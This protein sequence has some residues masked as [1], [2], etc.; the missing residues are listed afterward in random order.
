MSVCPTIAILFG[1]FLIDYAIL[2]MISLV[3]SSI[4][5]LLLARGGPLIV[6]PFGIAGMGIARI[7]ANCARR[8]QIPVVYA[9]C[10]SLSL[11]VLVACAFLVAVE[12]GNSVFILGALVLFGPGKEFALGIVAGSSATASSTS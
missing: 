2:A 1:S 12:V 9:I 7:L 10:R 11:A 8:A 4:S 3:F 5:A 6:A